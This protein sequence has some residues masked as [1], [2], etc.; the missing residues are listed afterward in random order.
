MKNRT[1]AWKHLL[2]LAVALLVLMLTSSAAF[3]AAG[4]TSGAGVLSPAEPHYGKTYAQWS[5][6]WWQWALSIS[7]HNP[8]YSDQVYHPLFDPTGTH[9]QCGVGQSGPVWF[10][11]GAF[12]V[13]GTAAQSTIVRDGCTVPAGK[14]LFFPILNNEC[15]FLEGKKFGCPGTTVDDLRQ[16]IKSVMD[17]AANL[18][19]D[20]DMVA[21]PIG[22]AT[23]SPYRVQSPAFA[24][25]LPPDDL[26]SAIGEGP[27]QPGTYSPMVGDGFYLLLAPLSVGQHTVHFHGEIPHLKFVLDVT[28]HL[29]VK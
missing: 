19:A 26:L 6:A 28:Y 4:Q 22:T 13:S 1:R 14:A 10:L 23:Q 17:R 11:G 16:D 9:T 8:P 5:A 29:T 25:T 7:V 21:I 12:V 27:F 15:S 3:A 24:F 2:T 20:V 18:S